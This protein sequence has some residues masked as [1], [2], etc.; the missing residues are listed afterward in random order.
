M[1]G[2]YD[3]SRWIIDGGKFGDIF[4]MWFNDKSKY[5]NIINPFKLSSVISSIKFSDKSS[6]LIEWYDVNPWGTFSKC[7]RTNFARPICGIISVL[8]GI[9]VILVSKN[10]NAESFGLLKY[11]GSKSWRDL[12]NIFSD[13]GEFVQT[14]YTPWRWNI[15]LFTKWKMKWRYSHHLKLWE[16]CTFINGVIFHG[17]LCIDWY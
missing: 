7:H 15:R 8:T 4:L 16:Y 17:E 5:C 1:F 14:D 10:S 9:S 12:F 13:K 3:K 2:L 11:S 6:T